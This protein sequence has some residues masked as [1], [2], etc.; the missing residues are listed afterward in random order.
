MYVEPHL[1]ELRGHRVSLAG[2]K[3]TAREVQYLVLPD[4]SNPWLLARVR[5]PDVFQAISPAEPDWRSDPGLF[6]LPYDPSSVAVDRDR[7]AAIA[8]EWGAEFPSAEDGA[9]PGPTLI[10][11][12]PAN[13]SELSPAAKH[14][15][16][17]EPD[18]SRSRFPAREP[19]SERWRRRLEG[20]SQAPG[21]SHP[22]REESIVLRDAEPADVIDLTDANEDALLTA[23]D[24]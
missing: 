24:S 9:V 11:R 21:N 12:M 8:A 15:W 6:D 23:E 1:E 4:A 17:I 7:A 18:R 20:V 10:R 3:T 14:A 2:R 22:Q 16:A 5:W 13:W 19:R